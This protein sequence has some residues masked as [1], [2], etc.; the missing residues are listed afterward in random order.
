MGRGALVPWNPSLLR[1]FD[2]MAMFDALPP[3]QHK[4]IVNKCNQP[5]FLGA[6]T[7]P[8]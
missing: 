6:M 5:V 2:Y 1:S 4:S 8:Y 7:M 3:A